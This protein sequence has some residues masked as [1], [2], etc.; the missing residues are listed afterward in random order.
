M[1]GGGRVH[2]GYRLGGDDPAHGSHRPGRPGAAAHAASQR[3]RMSAPSCA[4]RSGLG[5][6]R[7]NVQIALGDLADP[8][9]MR[10]ALRGRRHRHPPRGHDPRPAARL[11]R[12]AQRPRHRAG[13]CGRPSGSGSSASSSSRRSTPPSS[14]APASFAPRP[15]PSGRSSTADLEAIVLA[16]SIV[17]GPDDPWINLLERFSALPLMPVAGD[18]NGPLPADLGA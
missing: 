11:D 4:T 18:G 1:R 10:H 3:A 13:C 8:F 16:P 9:S 17:Y 6:N 5:A 2:A 14:S 15:S 7:V 12:G